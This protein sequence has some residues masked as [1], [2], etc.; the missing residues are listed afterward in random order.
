MSVA[1]NITFGRKV[2]GID[3]AT[4]DAKLAEVAKQLQIEA[5][6]NRRPA[7]LS[8]GNKDLCAKISNLIP[9]DQLLQWCHVTH[10]L[11]FFSSVFLLECAL[12]VIFW[13]SMR[14]SF[15]SAS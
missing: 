2:R 14:H 9:T 10:S 8:D 15:P 11:H 3:Q 12:R 5:L 13:D 4:Q 1:K 7:Q 6:L